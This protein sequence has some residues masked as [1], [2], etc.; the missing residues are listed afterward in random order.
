MS[1]LKV[2]GFANV[3]FCMNCVPPRF[4]VEVEGKTAIIKDD[5]IFAVKEKRYIGECYPYVMLD[6]KKFRFEL[7]EVENES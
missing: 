5:V 1:R 6:G 7:V 2:I 4:Q 3:S